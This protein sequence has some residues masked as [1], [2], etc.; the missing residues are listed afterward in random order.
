MFM[1][2]TIMLL[3]G[4]PELSLPDKIP[5]S[6]QLSLMMYLT[7]LRSRVLPKNKRWSKVWSRKCHFLRTNWKINKKKIEDLKMSR[8]KRNIKELKILGKWRMKSKEIWLLSTIKQPPIWRN[9]LDKLKLIQKGLR[10][11]LTLESKNYLRL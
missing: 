2:L 1:K 4:N 10:Q 8:N 5:G 3:D 11:N 7:Q 9:N 6:S